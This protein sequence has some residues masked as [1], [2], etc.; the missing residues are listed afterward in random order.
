MMPCTAVP[1]ALAMNCHS[2]WIALIFI[3]AES[4]STGDGRELGRVGRTDS[5]TR[6]VPG[7]YSKFP[8]M[9]SIGAATVSADPA[10][11]AEVPNIALDNPNESADGAS[12]ADWNA[13]TAA[14]DGAGAPTDMG[15]GAA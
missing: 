14:A 4:N 9:W 1:V 5:K 13:L 12:I 2:S 15:A 10:A 8:G 11:W 7:R 3:C 6:T